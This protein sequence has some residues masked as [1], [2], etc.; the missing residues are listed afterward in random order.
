MKTEL[1]AVVSA[2]LILLMLR[3]RM[4]A[5]CLIGLMLSVA[6]LEKTN[7][8]DFVSAWFL[9]HFMQGISTS[10]ALVS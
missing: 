5:A 2:I 7:L 9:I 1:A 4:E 8:P 6:G 3:E 10:L